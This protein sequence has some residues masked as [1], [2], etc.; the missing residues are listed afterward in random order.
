[1]HKTTTRIH[2]AYHMC[3]RRFVSYHLHERL[4]EMTHHRHLIVVP[5]LAHTTEEDAIEQ[6]HVGIE[7]VAFARGDELET[8]E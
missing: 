6:I 8:C 1:M 5:I 3:T 2:G 4:L 7:Q